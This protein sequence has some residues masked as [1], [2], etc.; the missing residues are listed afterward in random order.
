MMAISCASLFEIRL[1]VKTE[2][3]L[4]IWGFGIHAIGTANPQHAGA[5]LSEQCTANSHTD[6]HAHSSPPRG[7]GAPPWRIA[8]SCAKEQVCP[9]RLIHTSEGRRV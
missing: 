7:S 5:H 8:V 3:R 2:N 4:L 9:C 6:A 1:I